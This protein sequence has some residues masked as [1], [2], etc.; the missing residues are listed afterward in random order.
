[1]WI[2]RVW[3]PVAV[4][5]T[6][7]SGLL[8]GVVQQNYRLSLNDPQ[9]QIA[10]DVALLLRSGV[11]ASALAPQEQIN[12]AQS[13]SPW[14]AI[15]DASGTPI[16]SS[17]LL[18]GAMPKPPRGVF[19]DLISGEVHDAGLKTSL[20]AEDIAQTGENRLSWQPRANVRQA[21]VVVQ[22]DDGFVVAGRGMREVEQR[23]WQ[24]EMLIVLG[25]VVTLCATLVAAWLGSS[26]HRFISVE[27]D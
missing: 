12:I 11:K 13:L 19:D 17:G 15:Y 7:M 18:D 3:A 24:M 1:M 23:I 16:V 20:K 5:V 14:F 4:A 10:E 25:W 9:V 6:L 27:S 2:T 26:S 21:I 22:A 8:Y